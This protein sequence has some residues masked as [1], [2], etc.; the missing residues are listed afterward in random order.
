[1]S[2][3]GF[4]NTALQAGFIFTH[5]ENRHEIDIDLLYQPGQNNRPDS[6]RYDLSWQY[7]L[8]PDQRPDWGIVAETF[9]VMEFNGR[10]QQGKTVTQQITVG[11]QWIHPK[12]V[13]EGG[14]VQDINRNHDWSY[15]LSTRFHF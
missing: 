15:L 1:M 9:A 14:I 8:L 4:I 10:W 7:R 13:I 11:L 5:F 6:G 3:Y 12:L 2:A